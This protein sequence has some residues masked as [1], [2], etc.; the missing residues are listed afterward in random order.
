SPLPLHDALPIFP[1]RPVSPVK[2][3]NCL[4]IAVRVPTGHQTVV[5]SF[6]LG[7]IPGLN[8]FPQLYCGHLVSPKPS[9]TRVLINGSAGNQHQTERARVLATL[10]PS[11]TNNLRVIVDRANDRAAVGVLDFLLSECDE[12]LNR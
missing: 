11:P 4:A 1:T 10:D 2:H 7:V 12:L 6:S 3:R 9:L 5:S 8:P